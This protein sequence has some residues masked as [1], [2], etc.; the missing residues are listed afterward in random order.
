[1]INP[2]ALKLGPLSVRW[3]GIAY[4]VALGVGYWIITRLNRIRHVFKDN[5]QILDLAF[6]LFFWG[7]ILGGRLGF[8][9][10]YDLPY[11]L[12][13]P[14]KIAALWEGGM[15]FHGGLIGSILFSLWFC[16]KNKIGFMD[17]GDL[18]APVAALAQGIGRLGNFANLELPGRII[19]DPRWQFLAINFGDGQPRF[20]SPLLQSSEGLLAFG[21][22]LAL[23]FRKL[24]TGTVLA[25]YLMLNGLFRFLSEFYR[26]PD[27]Q[28]GYLFGWMTLGQILGLLVLLAG[29]GLLVWQNFHHRRQTTHHRSN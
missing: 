19:T 10:F 25:A 22:L 24:K 20:P 9:L 18:I 6:G 28:I 29:V 2:V 4:V 23:F 7:A 26:E 3:Y 15:S 27:P 8:V 21:I 17:A 1:M 13:N 16:R 12:A 14:L 11:F 5:D